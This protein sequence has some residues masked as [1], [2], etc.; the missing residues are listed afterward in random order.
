MASG[1]KKKLNPRK[2]PATEADIRRASDKA[3]DKAVKITLAIFLTVLCDDFS[4][5][6]DQ[7]QFAWQRLEKL[8]DAISEHRINVYDLIKV[9]SDEYEIDLI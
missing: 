3:S 7:I 9:L 2:R 4:F 1:N 5:T 6:K 8:S